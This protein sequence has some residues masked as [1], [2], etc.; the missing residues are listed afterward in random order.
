[1]LPTEKG[2]RAKGGKVRANKTCR[3]ERRGTYRGS[4]HSDIRQTSRGLHLEWKGEGGS[5][6][7]VQDQGVEKKNADWG[8]K[9]EL[10]GGSSCS[11]VKPKH[12]FIE[13][14]KKVEKRWKK[15]Q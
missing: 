9:R 4:F 2:G 6:W 1:M 12:V 13:K 8:K 3:T 14:E 11:G 10:R 15:S 5:G 7:T